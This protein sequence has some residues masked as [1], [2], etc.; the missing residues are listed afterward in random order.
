MKNILALITFLIITT[1]FAKAQDGWV[2]HKVDAHIAAKFPMEPKE[3]IPGTIM[4]MGKD[5]IGCLLTV[6]DLA[7]LG[8]IDSATLAGVKEDPQFTSQLKT[9]IEGG[10][11]GGKLADLT[12]GKWQGLT[13]YSS[14]GTDPAKSLNYIIYMIVYSTT[15]Y[16]FSTVGHG[17][18]KAKADVFFHSISFTK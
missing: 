8:A 5:S 10:L 6:I 3:M 14:T 17:D 13:T 12:V 9:G 16:S 2:N 7:K 15:I 18:T 4:A 11:K 1:T